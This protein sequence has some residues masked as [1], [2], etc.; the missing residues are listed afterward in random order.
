MA[1]TDRLVSQRARLFSVQERN[2]TRPSTLAR[3]CQATQGKRRSSHLALAGLGEA[4]QA[5]LS[6][7]DVARAE[8]WLP[9]RSE[10]LSGDVTAFV[11]RSIAFDRNTKERQLR[12]QRR[13]T[14]GAIAATLL[15]GIFG[16][17]ALIQ[18]QRA[19]R[20]EQIAK[21]ALA[22]QQRLNIELDQKKRDAEIRA[23]DATKEAQEAI[24]QYKEA[25]RLLEE[26]NKKGR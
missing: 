26:I 22:E 2:R 25:L 10:D 18:W 16:V 13:V 21:T 1:A 14:I 15:I 24:K 6:G 12:F 20:A 9:D 11:Q 3:G 5:L 8:K 23:E 7:L 19:E 17:S 4:D